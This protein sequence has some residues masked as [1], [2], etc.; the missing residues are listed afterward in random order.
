MSPL[1]NQIKRVSETLL[2]LVYPPRCAHC[3]RVDWRW[4]PTCAAALHTFPLDLTRRTIP[5]IDASAAT[6]RHS[7]LLQHAVHAL[8]YNGAIDVALP[9]G[10]RMAAAVSACGWQCDR[11]VAVPLARSRLRER[12][13]NQCQVIGSC[14]AEIIQ[15]PIAPPESLVRLRETP[16]QLGRD[17]AGRRANVRAAFQADAKHVS[18]AVIL[19][20]DDVMTSGATLQE[21]ALSLRAAGARAV[22]SL[23]VTEA[24]L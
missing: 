21:C 19:L 15:K 14:M 18:G 11:I 16:T 9:L 10:A 1:L 6:G 8:K 22:L 23:T 13:Y 24:R 7:G 3:G 20:L 4:C 2:D 5:H 17:H 12:G